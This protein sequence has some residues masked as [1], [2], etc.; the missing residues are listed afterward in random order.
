M[1]RKMNLN[2]LFL[3]RS[4]ILAHSIEIVLN[5]L[6]KQEYC[7]IL[8][9][10]LEPNFFTF[11]RNYTAKIQILPSLLNCYYSNNNDTH[12]MVVFLGIVEVLKSCIGGHLLSKVWYLYSVKSL[13]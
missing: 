5:K 2:F 10:E 6:K 4:G 1:M 12:L 8:I 11:Q 7:G 9:Q 13:S 3:S